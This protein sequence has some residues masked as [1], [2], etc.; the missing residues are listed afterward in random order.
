MLRHIH[1]QICG[2]SIPW[3]RKANEGG[4]AA[5]TDA[6]LDA[7]AYRAGRRQYLAEGKGTP[8]PG[9]QE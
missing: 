2:E 4:A 8:A 1:R 9:A 3:W 6:P 5:P 7:A